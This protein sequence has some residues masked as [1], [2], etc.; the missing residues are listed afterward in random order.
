MPENQQSSVVINYDEIIESIG[1]Q[2][3]FVL[4]A[5]LNSTEPE[6]LET[7]RPIRQIKV[8]DEQMFDYEN[9]SIAL[10]KGTLYI[11]VKFGLGAINYGSSVTPISLTCLGT[12]NKVKP[13]QLLLSV[14]SST[15]TTKNLNQGLENES[16]TM[17]QVWNTPEVISNFNVYKSGFRNLFRL[18]GNI[19]VG[20][21]AIRL[22]TLTYFYDEDNYNPET[23]YGA[24][25]VNVMSFQSTFHSSLDT[26]S[27]GNLKG[28]AKSE[29]N[30]SVY[31]FSISTYLLNGYF[32][33]AALS[34]MGFRN[35]STTG[36]GAIFRINQQQEIEQV[37]DYFFIKKN[38]KVKIKL[39][40][41]NGFTNEPADNEQASERDDILAD[42]FFSYFKIVDVQI[43]QELAGIPTLTVAFTR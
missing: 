6:I 14:F 4:N 7:I 21:S 30:F 38:Q 37:N 17:L 24:E 26:Q 20:P 34:L 11:I 31:N 42:D 18:T 43:G 41:S 16:T 25:T 28:F 12:E 40:F 2:F 23:G 19:V 32:S 22:G 13:A 36:I 27:F 8:S 9:E 29:V 3:Q 35:R 10:E 39:N 15:W 33:A 5:L 1:S